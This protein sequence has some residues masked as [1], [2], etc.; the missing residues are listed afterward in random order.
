LKFKLGI[1]TDEITQDL[2]K[3]LDFISQFSLEFCELRE[4][5]RKNI[6][7][8]SAD[9]RKLAKELIDKRH[10]RVSEIASPIMK[11]D[12]P[13]MPARAEKRPTFGAEFAEKDTE[14]LL[15]KAFELARFFGTDKIRLFSYWRVS[16]PQKAYPYVRDRLAKAA[17][18]ARQDDMLLILEN[19]H[20]C[21]VG[22][23][24]ELGRVLKDVNS[25]HLRGNWDP[26]NAAMLKEIP[27]PDG[28]LHVRGW[29]SHVHVKDV[30][31]DSRSGELRW[32]P[33]GGGFIDWRGQLEAL[34]RDG[35]EGT[36]SLETHYR[37][38]DGNELESTRE[39]LQGL[40]KLIKEV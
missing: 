22:T 9:E 32:A 8:L 31:E 23:G 18:L 19:E 30:K 14:A 12:L 38:P 10:L 25:L 17:E 1:I 3:A 26:G 39:S 11:Y 29:F 21:N 34:R 4:V 20:S 40:M 15:H 2:E 37:R 6:M 35:Y 33:V 28:Y 7:N 36:M 16:D 5:W 27:Y 13:E 24:E